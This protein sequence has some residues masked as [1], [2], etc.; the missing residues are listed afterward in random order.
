VGSATFSTHV[1]T[2]LPI[3]AE[4]A[5]YFNKG[6]ID[7]GHAS[8]G[9]TQPSK[10]W[11]FSEG[12]TR[13]FYESY[14]LVGNPG[15]QATVVNIDYYLAFASIR[16]SYLLGP[17]ARLTVPIASQGS[18]NN[19]DMG[20]T[21]SADQPIVAERTLYY[22]LDSHKGG[23]ATIGSTIPSQTWYFAEGY[24]G[25]TFDT[26]ITLANPTWTDAVANVTFQRDDGGVLTYSYGVPGQ[27]RI[28][29]KVDDLPGLEQAAFSTVVTS[30]QPIMAER[31]MFF[32]MTRGY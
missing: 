29:I 32:I 11:Y 23:S 15:D 17:K 9:A 4:R 13:N 8:I 2:D 26:Y 19:T 24:T 18:L 3:V 20:F 14:I 30:D 12:C 10:T 1:E 6:L 7:G 25:G 28:A 5:E 27:R 31:E 16:Y 22:G 21:V